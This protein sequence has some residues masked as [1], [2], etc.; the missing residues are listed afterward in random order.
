MFHPF[1]P[2]DKEQGHD[3]TAHQREIKGEGSLLL[4]TEG[5]RVHCH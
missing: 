2:V 1:N 4:R 3:G 5:R